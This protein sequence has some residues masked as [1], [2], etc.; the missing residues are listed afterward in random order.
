[1]STLAAGYLKPQEAYDY[2][3]S[4]PNVASVVVGVSR[5]DHAQET[6]QIIREHIQ[7]TV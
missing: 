2:L 1:M 4:L 6:F 7:E 3:F 5:K